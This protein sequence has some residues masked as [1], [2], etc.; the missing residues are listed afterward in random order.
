MS[1]VTPSMVILLQ[2]PIRMTKTSG[3]PLI[4]GQGNFTKPMVIEMREIY[5]NQ[6]AKSRSNPADIEKETV[7]YSPNYDG[8]EDIPDLP[9]RIP[10]LL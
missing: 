2:M 8:T 9:T 3:Y 7:T 6:N 5:R 10:N 4:Q 1:L